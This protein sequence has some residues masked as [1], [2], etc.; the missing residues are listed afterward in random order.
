MKKYK[1]CPLC[2]RRNPPKMLECIGCEAD[3]S[4]VCIIDSEI[5]Q[6]QSEESVESVTVPKMIRICDCG[7]ANP[8]NVRKCINCG[9][10]ISD[11]VPVEDVETEENNMRYAFISLDGVYTYEVVA[12]EIVIGR[13]AAMQDYLVSKPY[14]S[15]KHAMIIVRS[16]RLYIRNIS[17]TNYTY[18]NNEK[19]PDGDFELRDGDEIGLGGHGHNGSR[20]E[21]AAYFQVRAGICI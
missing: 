18:V 3:L 20:Q 14:V 4:N 5:E 11:I 16:G 6:R 8:V 15:R 9:E 19:I 12:A 7:V 10:A 13:E 1:V 2:G 21:E 17:R